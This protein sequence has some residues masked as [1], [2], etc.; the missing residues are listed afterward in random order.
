MVKAATS[1]MIK[2]LA[3][4]T[5]GGK[6]I[7][8]IHVDDMERIKND[9]SLR[10]NIGLKGNVTILK[11]SIRR[12]GSKAITAM[13]A[14]KKL[15]DKKKKNIKKKKTASVN[16]TKKKKQNKT[17]KTAKRVGVKYQTSGNK[18]VKNKVR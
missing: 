15:V 5:R 7:A 13:R 1:T 9:L 18:K 16:K 8:A 11:K 2:K 12:V 14:Q 4:V 17:I 6:N 10:K 3:N